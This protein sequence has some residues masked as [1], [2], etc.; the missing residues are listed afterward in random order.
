[1]PTE[2]DL[3]PLFEQHRPALRAV[4]LRLLG[5]PTEADDA[6]QEAWLRFRRADVASLD[7]VGGWL[8]TVTS[9]ICLDMLRARTS[10][11]EEPLA[12][13]GEEPARPSDGGGDPEHEAILADTVGAALQVVLE[14]LAPAE[15]LAF[16][17]HDV[18]AMPFDDISAVLGRSPNAAKQLA[19]RARRRTQSAPPVTETDVSRRRAVV[20]AFLAASRGGDLEGLIAL[21]DPDI[22]LHADQAA[23][24]MGSP[25][26]VRGA[27]AVAN[28]F[29]GRA[30]GA[31]PAL[32]DGIIGIAWAPGGRAKVAWDFTVIDGRV[33]RIDMVADEHSLNELEL[34]L[35]D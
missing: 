13:R 5:T 32:L 19:S 12:E 7:N 9:R 26:L 14:A 35:L 22:V 16:V 2:D 11:R 24:T 30:L 29:S 8:T 15:R 27:S 20:D 21:L 1:M 3:A 33:A 4:A 10:R 25:E 28:V 31:K 17:L 6:V 18:F 34:V 23:A